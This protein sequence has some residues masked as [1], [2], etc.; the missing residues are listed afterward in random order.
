MIVWCRNPRL[1]W[2]ALYPPA[3]DGVSQW[4]SNN[5]R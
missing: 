2:A 1:A 4:V 5:V 3:N